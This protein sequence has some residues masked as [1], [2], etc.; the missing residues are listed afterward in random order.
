MK[1]PNR[2]ECCE[3]CWRLRDGAPDPGNAMTV[4]SGSGGAHAHCEATSPIC[5][6]RRKPDASG[7]IVVADDVDLPQVKERILTAVSRL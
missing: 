1:F 7:P 3:R 2:V 4:L 5:S 6:D